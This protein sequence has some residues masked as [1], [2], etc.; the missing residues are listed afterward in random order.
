MRGEAWHRDV[1]VVDSEDGPVG[2][3]KAHAG[4]KLVARRP[5][6]GARVDGTDAAADVG[7]M[8]RAANGPEVEPA[9]EQHPV[10]RLGVCRPDADSQL[11]SFANR[12]TT[13]ARTS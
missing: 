7:A 1:A 10:D 9:V 13:P 12:L 4:A 11:P 8:R 3:P 5:V 6:S 2:Y